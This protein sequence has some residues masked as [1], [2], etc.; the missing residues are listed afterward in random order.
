VKQLEVSGS[1]FLD[2][3]VSNTNGEKFDDYFNNKRDLGG[4][5]NKLVELLGVTEVA[6]ILQP[7]LVFSLNQAELN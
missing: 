7:I 1:I 3:N 5:V 2:F 4:I 6:A